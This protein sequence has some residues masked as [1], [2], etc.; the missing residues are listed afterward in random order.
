MRS[1][2]IARPLGTLPPSHRYR[3]FD[4]ASLPLVQSRTHILALALKGLDARNSEVLH[5]LVA[6]ACQRATPFGGPAGRE[7][8]SLRGGAGADR[9]LS[10]LEDRGL[11]AGTGKPT[12]TMHIRSS[13]AWS[14]SSPTKRA[15][16]VLPAIAAHF[17]PM[18]TPEWEKVESLAD[19]APAIERYHTLVGLGR[20]DDAF[21][22]FRDRLEYATLYRLAAHRERIAWLERLFPNGTGGSPALTSDRDQSYTLNALALS[23]QLSGQ[24]GQAV[25]LFRHADQFDERRTDDNERQVGLSNLGGALCARL[26]AFREA[27]GVLRQA[28]VLNRMLKDKLWEADSLRNL[29]GLLAARGDAASSIALGRSRRL[30]AAST[31]ARAKASSLPISPNA[32][33]GAANSLRPPPSPTGHGN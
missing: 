7:E 20:Y 2:T 29:G 16:A 25:P 27:E 3:S 13:A 1:A 5:T 30:F 9:A 23:Y 14:G 32:R 31:I 10:E 17:E 33:S 15:G 12:A 21:T 18:A 24:P 19:L 22:L 26:G 11:M 8:K 28:L 4:P 6:S